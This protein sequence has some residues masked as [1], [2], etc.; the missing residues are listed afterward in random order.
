MRVIPAFDVL[1]MFKIPIL[2]TVYNLSDGQVEH[3]IHNRLSFCVFLGISFADTVPDS[4][5]I[6][7]FGEQLTKLGLGKLLF[8]R[9]YRELDQYGVTIK[10][11][12]AAAR[13]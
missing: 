8:D 11:E 3:Q 6:G 13:F 12:I 1:L 10:W 7:L 2:K 9:F 5:T 4:K